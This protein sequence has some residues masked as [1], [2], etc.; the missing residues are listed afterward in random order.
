MATQDLQHQN[1]RITVSVKL[2]RLLRCVPTTI[3]PEEGRGSPHF[4]P[5][6]TPA[7]R[8]FAQSCAHLLQ[9]SPGKGR[10]LPCSSSLQGPNKD[11]G[12]PMG[13]WSEFYGQLSWETSSGLTDLN[14]LSYSN[15]W[16]LCWL[17]RFCFLWFQESWDPTFPSAPL[18]HWAPFRQGS[19]SLE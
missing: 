15:A 6:Q 5:L 11:S 4:C 14:Q 16:E 2:W 10:G 19:L 3:L 9:P 1:W 18:Y 12:H 8:V 13:P 17:R 7:Q